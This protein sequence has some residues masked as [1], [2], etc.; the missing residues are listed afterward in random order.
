MLARISFL[1]IIFLVI[2]IQAPLAQTVD[3]NNSLVFY[4]DE[5]ATQR[6]WYGTGEVTVYLTAGPMVHQG[7]PCSFLNSWQCDDLIIDPIANVTDARIT[8]RGV[9]SPA[10][11]D[12][13]DGWTN[14]NVT[15]LEPLPLNGRTVVAELTLNVIS[16]D[17]T[18]LIAWGSYFVADDV[19]GLFELLTMGP[20]GPMDM[21]GH[22]ASIN[23]LSPVSTENLNWNLI[24]S[25][26]R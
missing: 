9:A 26:Y 4:F 17:P 25:L 20:H 10:V 24:K 18:A 19:Q 11:V 23:D 22:S 1:T 16:P 6:S 7:E 5:D 21:T 8:M 13:P 2:S 15:L 12:L 14:L 3:E